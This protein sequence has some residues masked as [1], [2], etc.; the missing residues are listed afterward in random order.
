MLPPTAHQL[1]TGLD[2]Q[3][4]TELLNFAAFSL[5]KPGHNSLGNSAYS[6][7]RQ[8]FYKTFFV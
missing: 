8:R 7:T 6:A 5:R 4:T 2:T 1:F 3:P